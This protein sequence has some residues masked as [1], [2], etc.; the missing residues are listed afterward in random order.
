[1]EEIE[2]TPEGKF[3]ISI[4][5]LLDINQIIRDIKNISLRTSKPDN[6]PEYLPRG[7]GQKLK[8]KLIRNFHVQST[9]LIKDE[10]TM[11]AIWKRIKA[12]KIKLR[13][14]NMCATNVNHKDARWTY[15]YSEDIENE[16]DEIMIDIQK[17]LQK[18]KLFMKLEDESRLF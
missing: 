12:I 3:N 10:K 17:Q 4:Q 2:Q 7:S 15:V 14:T 9:P 1:M 13:D 8:L 6:N 11:D 16:L 18:S 5:I